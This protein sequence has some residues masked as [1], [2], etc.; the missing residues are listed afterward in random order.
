MYI[1]ILLHY[2]CKFPYRFLI[3]HFDLIEHVSGGREITPKVQKL[4]RDKVI[5]HMTM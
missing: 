4:E 1:T 3:N 2:S 5:S